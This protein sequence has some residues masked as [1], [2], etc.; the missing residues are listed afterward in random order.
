MARHWAENTRAQANFRE[1]PETAVGWRTSHHFT[2]FGNYCK[3]P[4]QNGNRPLS[5]WWALCCAPGGISQLGSNRA[6]YILAA[7]PENSFLG[8]IMKWISVFS[9]TLLATS[10]AAWP[11]VR[12][13][14]TRAF[15]LDPYLDSPE[16]LA[17]LAS[18]DFHALLKRADSSLVITEAVLAVNKSGVIWT[19]LDQAASSPKTILYVANLTTSAVLLLLPKLGGISLTLLISGALSSSNSSLVKALEASGLLTSVLDGILLDDN[20]RPVLVNLTYRIVDSNKA[21]L[22]FVFDDV[23]QTQVKKRDTSTSGSLQSF[24]G[25]ALNSILNLAAVGSISGDL[26]NALNDTGVAVYTVK[27]LIADESYQNM[28]FELVL[29]IV[30]SGNL[31]IDLSS[32]NISSLLAPILADPSSISDLAKQLLSGSSSSS[33]SGTGL[34]LSKYEPALK[35]IVNDLELKGLFA[36]LNTYIFSS[37]AAAT[38][39]ATSSSAPSK[40]AVATTKAASSSSQ[41]KKDAS[42]V[43]QTS[44]SSSKSANAAATQASALMWVPSVLFGTL[45][46]L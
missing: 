16:G 39:Q 43:P 14:E 4:A 28:T 38:Q 20:Y 26:F 23:L 31:N 10:A 40:N 3:N 27:R 35:D 42:A 18:Y 22:K 6:D 46:L 29:D 8:P 24:L 11:A 25:N 2:A 36:D 34:N 12:P 30:N 19:V 17:G 21:T 7:V 5:P 13:K 9:A 44:A 33:S 41:G 32:L 37:S 45:L 15:D 1:I